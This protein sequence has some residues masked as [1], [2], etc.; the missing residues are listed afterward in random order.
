MEIIL[1]DIDVGI[2]RIDKIFHIS[3]IHIRLLKRHA[4]Y[5]LV[6]EKLYAEIENLKTDSS[7]IYIGGD[8]VHSKNE[9]SPE[10]IDVT[11]NFFKRLSD[12]AP[13][14]IIPGNHDTVLNNRSRLDSLS[15]IIDNI[16]NKN[17]YYI[18]E[19][20]IYN[21]A[22]CTFVLWS[23]FD[24]HDTSRFIKADDIT[25]D[26]KILLFHGTVDKSKTD[27]GYELPSTVKLD[28]MDGFDIVMMGDIHKMQTLQEYNKKGGKPIVRF[29]GDLLQQN[30]GESVYGHGLSLWDVPN[31]TFKHIEIP[32]DYGYYTLDIDKGV[33]P[34]VSDIPKKARLRIRVVNTSATELKKALTVI[35]EK[36]GVHETSVTKMDALYSTDRV[37]NKTIQ[38]GDVSSTDVQYQLIVDY[39]NANHIVDDKTLI[40]IKNINE[41]LNQVIPEDEVYR[42]VS[43]KLKH[44][45]FSNMFSYGEDNVVDFTKLNGIV[46]LFAPN[47]SGKCV[48]EST[49]IDIEYDEQ[50]IIDKLGFLP[51]ELK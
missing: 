30:H 12:I 24:E 8:V 47:T 1:I 10:L 13:T 36:Y 20:G 7:L 19:T 23:V 27:M 41:S 16:N 49:E 25:G 51:D 28:M 21:I 32:N 48:E 5:N 29:S 43:W 46:G 15:P 42:N 33:V 40:D 6:F 14:I 50:Y 45:E 38:I 44:F 18:K 31:R 37:R 26:T 35:H 4:E 39:L 22:D 11:S 17:L 3:D 34:D 9:M 2:K